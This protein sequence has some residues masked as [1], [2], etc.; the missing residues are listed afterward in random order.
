MVVSV[1]SSVVDRALFNAETYGDFEKY[2]I[3]SLVFLVYLVYICFIIFPP[4]L[5]YAYV[6][7]LIWHRGYIPIYEGGTANDRAMRELAIYFGRIIVV[8]AVVW[9]PATLFL[10]SARLWG[11]YY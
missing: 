4:F 8:F 10:W 1:G 5:Y 3:V 9:I 11:R 2:Q 7:T 6:T